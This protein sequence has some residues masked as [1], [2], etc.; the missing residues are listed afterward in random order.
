MC[1]LF[2]PFVCRFCGRLFS[3]FVNIICRRKKTESRKKSDL[4]FSPTKDKI[5]TLLMQPK[6]VFFFFRPLWRHHPFSLSHSSP[7]T[8]A[9]TT[10]TLYPIS[11]TYSH[12]LRGIWWWELQGERYLACLIRAKT[13]DHKDLWLPPKLNVRGQALLYVSNRGPRI[14]LHVHSSETRAWD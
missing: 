5:H 3:F 6:Q 8:R 12:W 13:L 10:W 1:L 7:I 9:A 2:L 4:H 11:R 14:S